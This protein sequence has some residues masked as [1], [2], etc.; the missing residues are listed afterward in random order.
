M[1]KSPVKK[2]LKQARFIAG[3]KAADR[4]E[5]PVVPRINARNDKINRN[6][7]AAVGIDSSPARKL[8]LDLKNV[9]IRTVRSGA[10]RK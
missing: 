6:M 3:E 10:K 5:T 8:Q 2:A 4:Y 1:A 9:G 7:K